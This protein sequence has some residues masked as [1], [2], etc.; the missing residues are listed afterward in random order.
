[1]KSQEIVDYIM[2]VIDRYKNGDVTKEIFYEIID[3]FVSNTDLEYYENESLKYVL[4][5][6][7]PGMLVY[8]ILKNQENGKKKKMNFGKQYWNVKRYLKKL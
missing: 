2:S 5:H 6:L 4:E 3:T 1:M 8:F 7:I